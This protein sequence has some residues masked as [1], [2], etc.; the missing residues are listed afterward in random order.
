MRVVNVE[1]R[2]RALGYSQWDSG[3]RV[4]TGGIGC[5]RSR[6]DAD[7]LGELASTS[8]SRE[9]RKRVLR[10][11]LEGTLR[12]SRASS[13]CGIAGSASGWSLACVLDR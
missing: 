2:T 13:K 4:A 7:K 8:R 5:R 1:R 10:T 11:K 3:H 9:I 6:H 12:L